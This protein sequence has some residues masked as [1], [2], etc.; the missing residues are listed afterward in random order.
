MDGD[1]LRRGPRRVVGVKQTLKRV[2]EG[3]AEVVYL[4]RDA[5]AAVVRSLVTAAELRGVQVTYVDTMAELG[6]L[7]G[8]Q[9]GAAA[10]A[11]V[12]D[13]Q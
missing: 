5:D 6:R 8:I 12:R 10:A 3:R 2:N 9:V 4:A 1:L 7:C 13:G 11:V